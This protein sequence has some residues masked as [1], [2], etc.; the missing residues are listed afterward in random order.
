MDG[1]QNLVPRP[2]FF[3][4][5]VLYQVPGGFRAGWAGNV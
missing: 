5:L 4:I 2:I 3:L 1:G